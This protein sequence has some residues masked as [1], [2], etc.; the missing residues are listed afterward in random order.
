MDPT[1]H[2]A[3]DRQSQRLLRRPA[4]QDEFGQG[5]EIDRNAPEE[6]VERPHQQRRGGPAVIPQGHGIAA[7]KFRPVAA[8]AIQA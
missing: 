8:A 3:H 5:K 7:G 2:R 4:A 1:G 6:G